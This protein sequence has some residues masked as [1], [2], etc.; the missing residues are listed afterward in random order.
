M[1]EGKVGTVLDLPL[2]KWGQP[3]KKKL[4]MEPYFK[5]GD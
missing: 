1:G 5:E 2:G 3:L 4:G